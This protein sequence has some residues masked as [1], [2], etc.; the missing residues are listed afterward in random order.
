MN[1]MIVKQ[2]LSSAGVKDGR[3]LGMVDKLMG[4]GLSDVAVEV[5]AG[6]TVEIPAGAD[7]VRISARGVTDKVTL[8]VVTE[9]A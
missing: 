7:T 2:L 4:C 8:F 6:S 1:A 9:K 5:F 3:V